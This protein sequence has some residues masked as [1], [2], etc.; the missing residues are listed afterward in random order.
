MVLVPLLRILTDWDDRKIFSSSVAII[1]P[2]C[3]VSLTVSA[4][5][6]AIPWTQALPYLAGS[7]LGGIGAGI[8]GKQIPVCW[9]HRGLGILMLWGGIRYLW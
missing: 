4:M 8:L 2:V 1:L 9:L 3:V 5:S 6:S 7:A